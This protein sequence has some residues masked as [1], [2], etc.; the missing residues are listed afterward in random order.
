MAKQQLKG[1]MAIGRESNNNLMLSYGKSLLMKNK[2]KTLAE[3][4]AD[5]DSI[6]AEE[7]QDIAQSELNPDDFDFLSFEGK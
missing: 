4:Y 5:L 6:T 1:Q 2:V 7:I 3:V